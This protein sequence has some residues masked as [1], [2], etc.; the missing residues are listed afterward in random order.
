MSHRQVRRVSDAYMSSCVDVKMSALDLV[1][2]SAPG[3]CAGMPKI[4]QSI[5]QQSPCKVLC[6]MD[7]IYLV[8]QPT[9]ADESLEGERLVCS[10]QLQQLYHCKQ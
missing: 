9:Q 2:L 8:R 4:P 1:A 7:E 5:S 6:E 3:G 10:N